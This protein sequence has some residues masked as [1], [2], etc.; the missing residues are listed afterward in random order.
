MVF[1]SNNQA[2]IGK[3]TVILNKTEPPALSKAVQ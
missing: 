2:E 1:N 3:Q